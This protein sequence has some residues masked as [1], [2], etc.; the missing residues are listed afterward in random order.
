[1]LPKCVPLLRLRGGVSLAA[2]PPF[3][4]CRPE[5]DIVFRM[6][7]TSKWD[8]DHRNTSKIDPKVLPKVSLKRSLNPFWK[9]RAQMEF[10]L[11]FTI[12]SAGWPPPETN[13]FPYI[14]LPKMYQKLIKNIN[15]PKPCKLLVKGPKSWK[16]G[17]TF[18]ANLAPEGT[19]T[20]TT[21]HPWDSR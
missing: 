8:H 18:S 3:L 16:T 1:M 20:S 15:R 13:R 19:V 14:W 21:F 4:R 5:F 6:L 11:L 7:K 12:Y 17:V 2:C 9:K 10:D